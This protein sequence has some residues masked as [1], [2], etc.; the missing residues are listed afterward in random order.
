MLVSALPTTLLAL[1]FTTALAAPLDP[2]RAGSQASV[3]WA[4]LLDQ[5]TAELIAY[6]PKITLPVASTVWREGDQIS[7]AWYV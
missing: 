4:D 7:I 3:A 5:P 1:L 2:L 6:F